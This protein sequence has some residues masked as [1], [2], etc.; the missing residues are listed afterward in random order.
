MQISERI[1]ETGERHL[2]D[3]ER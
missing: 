1:A 3:Q 2:S